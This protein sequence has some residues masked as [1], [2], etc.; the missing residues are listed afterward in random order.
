MAKQRQVWADQ[1]PSSSGS[2]AETSLQGMEMLQR[3]LLT[4]VWWWH[5]LWRRFW[6]YYCCTAFS[7]LPG[8]L[9]WIFPSDSFSTVSVFQMAVFQT[10]PMREGSKS[11]CWCRT[12]KL[13]CITSWLCL[14]TQL[15][16]QAVSSSELK[17][18]RRV[19]FERKGKWLRIFPFDC[20]SSC[21]L[22]RITIQQK[23]RRNHAG[24]KQ[25]QSVWLLVLCRAQS[26]WF[27]ACRVTIF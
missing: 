12:S 16:C 26:F 20:A 22:F 2:Q 15:E 6:V 10:C 3:T 7:L 27:C 19:G 9:C 1:A 17:L 23:Q 8:V 11:F 24:D 13:F 21:L 25:A 18:F 4:A 5:L 14:L